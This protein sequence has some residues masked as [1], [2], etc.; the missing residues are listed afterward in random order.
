MTSWNITL[1][2]WCPNYV[3]MSRGFK[4][5]RKSIISNKSNFLCR[6]FL[7]LWTCHTARENLPANIFYVNCVDISQ[8]SQGSG[9]ALV[10]SHWDQGRIDINLYDIHRKIGTQCEKQFASFPIVLCLLSCNYLVRERRLSPRQSDGTRN[11]FEL[12]NK[13]TFNPDLLQQFGWWGQTLFLL[14]VFFYQVILD[15]W[16]PI[17]HDNSCLFEYPFINILS[18]SSTGVRCLSPELYN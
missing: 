8:W 5:I 2:P 10:C 17:E 4:L 7:P 16:R 3:F 15:I 1:N 9:S 6:M 11:S 18:V 13:L 12:I 14:S